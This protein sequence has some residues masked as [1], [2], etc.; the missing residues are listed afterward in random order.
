M[1]TD[2]EI[3]D[4]VIEEIEWEPRVK[5]T[6][7]GV[8]VKDGAVTL[9]GTVSN[10]LE[11]TAAEQATRRVRG[12][13]AIAEN[14]E[15]VLPG[16]LAVSDEKIAEEIARIFK[17]NASVSSTD[18][19]AEVRSGIVTLIGNV[20]WNFQREAA[21]K[22]VSEI[23]G[24]KAVLNQ[25]QLKTRVQPADVKKAITRALH[26][27]ADVEAGRISV[28]VSG[29]K[30]TLKGDVKAWYERRLAEEAAWAAPGVTAVVDDLRVV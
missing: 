30:V 12:V 18:I 1:R 13:K 3:R 19:R 23:T 22:L 10:Y 15:V 27:N 26:R 5:S 8:T 28:E 9:S 4:D 29:G 7:I 25:V 11:K 20:D 14:I 16:S 6:E 17:W 2:K 24:V 21:R